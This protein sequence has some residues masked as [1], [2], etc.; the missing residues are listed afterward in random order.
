M[1]KFTRRNFLKGSLSSIVLALLEACIPNPTVTPTPTKTP[2]RALSTP[3]FPT[4]T[5]TFPPTNTAVPPTDT[6]TSS[7]TPSATGV[8]ASPTAS[9]TPAPPTPTPRP[10][11]FPPGPPTKLG[12]MVTRNH[13][14]MFE[15]L[16]TK[17]VAVVKTLEYDSTFVTDIKRISPETLLV[18]RIEYQLPD[19]GALDPM[20]EARRFA[21]TLLPIATEEKRRAA[22]DAWEASNEPVMSDVEQMKRL[23][24]FEAERTRL[25]AAEGIRSVIGNFGTGMPPLEMWPHFRAALEAA[26]KHEGYL[27]L[28]EYSAPTMY[29]NTTRDR[30]YPGITPTDNGWLTLRYRNVYRQHLIPMGLAIPLII[31]ECGI[32]GMV[33]NHPGPD[34]KGWQDFVGY[35]Q[36]ELG[37]GA[38][39]AGNYI[40]QLA[41]YDAGLQQDDYIKGAAIFALGGWSDWKSYDIAGD[42][43]QILHQYLSVHP[44][45]E[46]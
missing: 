7:V 27:G 35:W 11:P 17:N 22:V 4:A 42:A 12:V 36:H 39:G 38:D 9:A 10:T 14:Q 32:D 41:W 8:P 18:G 28:H 45:R 40:E 2:S 37:M 19:L 3:T 6:A 21:D 43:A 31:T 30:L 5:S 26:Q 13:P 1:K 34:G 20:G 44:P 15:L 29:F 23:A 24:E 16:E 25:L 46:S 33:Y